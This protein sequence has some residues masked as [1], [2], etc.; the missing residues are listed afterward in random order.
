[1]AELLD[2]DAPDVEDFLVHWLAPVLRCAVERK[3]DDPLPFATVVRI[4]GTDDPH[5]GV[6]DPVVQVDIFDTVRDGLLATQAA[7]ISARNIH[8]RMTLLMREPDHTVLMSDARHAN[9]DYVATVLRPFRMAYADDRIVRYVARYQV[10]L[11]YV[12]V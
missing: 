1:M 5:E 6:D 11:S 7:A 4:S 3:A 12:A 9:C 2:Q 10:G 8:R